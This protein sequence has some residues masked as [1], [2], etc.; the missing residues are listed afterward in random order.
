L[1]SGGRQGANHIR[2]TEFIKSVGEEAELGQRK[3]KGKI[4]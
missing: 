3:D 4:K 2:G 1:L